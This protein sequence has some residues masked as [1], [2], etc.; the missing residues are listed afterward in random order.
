[1]IARISPPL[2]VYRSITQACTK[3]LMLAPALEALHFVR[4]TGI[5][6]EVIGIGNVQLVDERMAHSPNIAQPCGDLQVAPT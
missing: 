3:P 6:E 2:F 1:M 4:R 5:L